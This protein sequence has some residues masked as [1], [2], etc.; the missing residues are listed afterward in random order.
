MTTHW[1]HKVFGKP[2]DSRLNYRVGATTTPFALVLKGSIFH[3]TY[4]RDT[5]LTLDR[6]SDTLPTSILKLQS[7][8]HSKLDANLKLSFDV[9]ELESAYGSS[10]R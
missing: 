4:N 1:M 6:K 3:L 10:V 2:W 5:I 9:A 8:V 7:T